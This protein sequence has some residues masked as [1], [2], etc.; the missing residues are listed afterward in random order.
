MITT[1]NSLLL[2]L[3]LTAI[4]YILIQKN[5]ISSLKETNSSLYKANQQMIADNHLRK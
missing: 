1:L 3:L 2:L 4:A 5:K